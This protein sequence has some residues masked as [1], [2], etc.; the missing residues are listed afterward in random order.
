MYRIIIQRG[1]EFPDRR[2]CAGSLQIGA[3]WGE[4]G[5]GAGV[6]VVGEPVDVSFSLDVRRAVS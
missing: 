5:A 6:L 3:P 4:V 2:R 1:I